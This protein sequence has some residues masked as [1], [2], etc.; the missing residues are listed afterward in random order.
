MNWLQNVMLES[1][2]MYM[3]LIFVASIPIALVTMFFIAKHDKKMGRED[4]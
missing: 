4:V 2:L 3:L 1:P